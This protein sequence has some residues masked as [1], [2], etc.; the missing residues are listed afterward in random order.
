MYNILNFIILGD[1]GLPGPVVDIKGDKGEPGPPGFDGLPGPPGH[2]GKKLLT[3]FKPSDNNSYLNYFYCLTT[4][5]E[6]Y[7]KFG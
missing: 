4:L 3:K 1:S 5:S 7:V 2:V 6:L